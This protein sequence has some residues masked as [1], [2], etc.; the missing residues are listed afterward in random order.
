[1]TNECSKRKL[2]RTG[3]G[4]FPSDNV[5]PQG[6]LECRKKRQPSSRRRHGGSR[7]TGAVQGLRRS[8]RRRLLRLVTRSYAWLRIKKVFFVFDGA[9]LSVPRHFWGVYR[10]GCCARGR[11]H[12]GHRQKTPQPGRLHGEEG[13]GVIG[14]LRLFG[15]LRDCGFADGAK[16]WRHLA[17]F[18]AFVRLFPRFLEIFFFNGRTEACWSL[19]KF[20]PMLRM[21]CV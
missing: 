8:E 7:R 14:E 3:V 6:G 11:A 13:G 9:H 21:Y 2:Q 17:P 5:A 10:W 19:P 15:R 16:N 12:S 20:N 18:C 4:R 1:M